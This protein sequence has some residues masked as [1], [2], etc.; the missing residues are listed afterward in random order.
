MFHKFSKGKAIAVGGDGDGWTIASPFYWYRHATDWHITSGLNT[1]GSP[2][3][4]ER[5]IYFRVK[6]KGGVEYAL[7]T[8]GEFDGKCWLYNESGAELTYNDD[9]S[10]EVNGE[11]YS[12]CIWYT[13]SADGIFIFR[14]G[15][16]SDGQGDIRVCCYPAPET[17]EIPNATMVYE[18][19]SGFNALGLPIKYR[20][21]DS[22]EIAFKTHPKKNLV[23]RY[24]FKSL[25]AET[26]Q[27]FITQK[28]TPKFTKSDN[29]DC[30]FLDG[31]T[32]IYTT[33]NTDRNAILASGKMAASLWFK[34][35]LDTPHG[36]IL[37]GRGSGG[38][39]LY[40]FEYYHDSVYGNIG[41]YSSTNYNFNTLDCKWHH[42]V[43]S[44]DSDT[45]NQYSLWVD[46]VKRRT[47]T[48]D[49]YIDIDKLVVGADY[50]MGS[51]FKGYIAKVRVYD[52]ALTEREIQTLFT[53]CKPKE[54]LGK[55]AY[56]TYN[57][58]LT[59][60]SSVGYK[61][62][63]GNMPRTVSAWIKPFKLDGNERYPILK[64]G[65]SDMD[66]A[67]F[68]LGL[69]KQ[70]SVYKLGL[71]L[72]NSTH[73]TDYTIDVNKWYNVAVC[74][75]GATTCYFYVNGEKVAELTV[76]ELSTRQGYDGGYIGYDYYSYEGLI[77]DINIYGRVLS[78]REIAMLYNKQTV[79]DGLMLNIPLASGYDNNNMFTSTPRYDY[80]PPT[81]G[82]IELPAEEDTPI[83]ELSPF[84]KS[85]Y[86]TGAVEV[87]LTDKAPTTVPLSVSYW[88]KAEAFGQ[89]GG[90]WF[91][92]GKTTSSSTELNNIEFAGPSSYFNL[93][94]GHSLS[95]DTDFS[96]KAWYHIVMTADEENNILIFVNGEQK[97]GTTRL[98]NI[99][100]NKLY[101]GGYD[102]TDYAPSRGFAGNMMELNIYNKVLSAD[103]IT[104][105]YN[106]QEVT[107]G[108]VVYIPLQ[109]GK[110]N[111]S[112]F[113]EKNF[114]YGEV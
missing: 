60:T 20:N 107:S 4:Y 69:I 47:T 85:A 73:V 111:D 7:G 18:T 67:E 44:F 114:S 39:E 14:A 37:F 50:G 100:P 59:L 106:K 12:D 71:L 82:N 40:N 43:I 57:G 27:V 29:V 51:C 10:C 87:D 95:F 2:E 70:D 94:N 52:R 102:P 26:G 53:E 84:V 1:S 6:L 36:R 24:D 83:V 108:R 105:L 48:F 80:L 55:P 33:D 21:A 19:S 77:T 91:D 3:S 112:M 92:W 97:A 49:R 34:A 11:Y 99:N 75:D 103:E 58:H 86:L 63:Y 72:C 42:L 56:L 17:E 96:N 88:I 61:F 41:D 78:N 74:Y 30:I 38:Y 101:L 54:E 113:T 109:F 31:D 35:T 98:L 23:L 32:C 93:G 5:S 66:L 104:A 65:S 45:S 90:C 89:Y 76:P 79:S 68:N 81:G 64:Y 16:Y 110:D 15:A 28:G 46:G 62:P 25:T 13:P 22:A 8:Y 9:G